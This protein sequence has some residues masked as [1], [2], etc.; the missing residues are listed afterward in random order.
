MWKTRRRVSKA[1]WESS[2]CVWCIAMEQTKAPGISE[3]KKKK[4]EQRSSR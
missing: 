3:K 1:L 2:G 4:D